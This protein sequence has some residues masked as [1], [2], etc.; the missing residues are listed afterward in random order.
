MARI[1]IV[2]TSASRMGETGKP[3]GIWLPETAVDN[4]TLRILCDEGIRYTILAPWQAADA[5]LD[6]GEVQGQFAR[7]LA[8]DLAFDGLAEVH[9]VVG[10]RLQ[11]GTQEYL[12]IE[13][14]PTNQEQ[15]PKLYVPVSEA[16]KIASVM[17]ERKL[18]YE[19]KLYKNAGH[20]FGTLDMM[21][22]AKRAYFFLK[23]HLG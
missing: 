1:L 13:Y 21:D 23:K 2:V 3:T 22:A 12:V 14:A 10:E 20:G 5:R 9:V 8:G 17:E 19:M 4:A 15:P 7:L 11:E 16:H 18:P 6:A